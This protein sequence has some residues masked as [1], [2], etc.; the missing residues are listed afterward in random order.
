MTTALPVP[1]VLVTGAAR[2]VGAEIARVLHAAGAGVAIHY[3][4]S[5]TEAEELAATLNKARAESAAAFAADLL[6]LAALPRLVDSRCRPLR[7][8]RRAGE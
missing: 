1:V 6:D 8:A 4:S 3:R 5:A 2:R 7:Q